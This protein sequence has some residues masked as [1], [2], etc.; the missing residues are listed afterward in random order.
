MAKVRYK[1]AALLMS[2]VM[3]FSSLG[4]LPVSAASSGTSTKRTICQ[5][6]ILQDDLAKLVLARQGKNL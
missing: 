5:V 1:V 2:A 4:T 6:P 3:G